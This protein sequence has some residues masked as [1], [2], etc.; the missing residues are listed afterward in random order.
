MLGD[1]KFPEDEDT[2]LSQLANGIAVV[3]ISLLGFAMCRLLKRWR[4]KTK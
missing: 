3:A 1:L 4:S 2:A